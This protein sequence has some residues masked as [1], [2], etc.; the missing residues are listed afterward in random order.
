MLAQAVPEGLDGWGVWTGKEQ[1][2]DPRHRC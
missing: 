1:H 2:P